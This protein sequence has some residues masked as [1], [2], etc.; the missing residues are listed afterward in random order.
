MTD[1][2]EEFAQARQKSQGRFRSAFEAIFEKYSR[3]DEDDDVVDLL[4]GKIVVDNGRIRNAEVIELGDLLRYSDSADPSSH[5]SK[6]RHDIGGSRE[7]TTSPELL[8]N[9]DLLRMQKRSDSTEPLDLDFAPWRHSHEQIQSKRKTPGRDSDGISALNYDSSDSLGTDQDTSIDMY[10]ASTIEQYMEKLRNGIPAPQTNNSWAN[11]ESPV[12]SNTGNAADRE[13]QEDSDACS[14]EE[15][16]DGNLYRVHGHDGAYDYENEGDMQ[17]S[18]AS[19]STDK[20]FETEYPS[21]GR[22]RYTIPSSPHTMTSVGSKSKRHIHSALPPSIRNSAHTESSIP[23]TSSPTRPHEDVFEEQ[24]PVPYEVHDSINSYDGTRTDTTLNS[25]AHLIDESDLSGEEPIEDTWV[26]RQTARGETASEYSSN[27]GCV[28]HSIAATQSKPA[29]VPL[30]PITRSSSML[31]CTVNNKVATPAHT[32]ADSRRPPVPSVTLDYRIPLERPSS[33][34]GRPALFKPQPVAPHVFFDCGPEPGTA[35][36]MHQA[37]LEEGG[38]NA[39]IHSGESPI[40]VS[41]KP[42]V[43]SLAD[44]PYETFI[45]GETYESYYPPCSTYDTFYET[46]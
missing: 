12:F 16:S 6:R 7:G 30:P 42:N 21:G 37:G 34:D 22:H 11:A 9:E 20:D 39:S 5:K 38:D 27:T 40:P 36:H 26:Y 13:E 10:F 35:M 8:T 41:S 33:T 31:P 45:G 32:A 29:S 18:E 1:Q 46:K 44:Q 43:Q 2:D 23:E 15:D 17:Y 25:I 3:V 14:Y 28:E 19:Y 4:T 24:T